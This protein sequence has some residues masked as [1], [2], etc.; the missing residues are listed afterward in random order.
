MWRALCNGALIALTIGL[1]ACE[2]HDQADARINEAARLTGE[3]AARLAAA[4]RGEIQIVDSPYYGEAVRVPL[5]QT[6]G[7]RLPQRV[8]AAKGST[9]NLRN[10]SLSD[11]A[12]A[13][14][15][16]NDIPVNIRTLYSTR[17]WDAVDVRPSA[18]ITL[19]HE[20]ALSRALDIVAART[21][22]Q[23]NYD[24]TA[25]VFD[26]MVTASY[27][28]P[29]PTGSSS[30]SSTV[31][32][33]QATGS[34]VSLSRNSRFE[35][36][37]EI[38]TRLAQAVPP[39]GE[40]MLNRNAGTI[41]VLGPPSVQAAAER[42]VDEFKAIYGARIGLEIGIFFVDSEKLSEFEGGIEGS[43][44]RYEISGL[45]TALAGNGVATLTG[46]N[47]TLSFRALA[48]NAAVV[49][50]RQASS[51]AQSGVW[52]PTIIRSSTN[53]VSGTETSTT[54]GVTST[55]IQTGTVDSGLSIHALPRI[56]NNGNIHLSLTILQSSLNGLDEFT[57]SDSTVQLP[58][59]DQR[60]LQNDAILSPGET[61]VLAGY[62][63]EY[64]T[65]TERRS[66]LF[67]GGTS[68]AKV[69]KV[70]MIVLVRPA[71][72]AVAEGDS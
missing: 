28:V 45:T 18:R 30:F 59:I 48:R 53:Y 21:D 57:S 22:T 2:T 58:S 31:D 36:W 49:D 65:R 5:G 24:G 12:T 29:L 10:S 43:G 47:A 38:E 27:Q 62:E 69:Y 67:L 23:W 35:P 26:S 40:F 16:Q 25:I 46:G 63:Q 56:V 11:F 34:T 55:S 33:L 71:I 8:E 54:D 3:Q 13:V 72:L 42:V 17:N 44:S 15:N 14:T 50:F 1:T 60:A 68:D 9:F 20:G 37:E 70:R 19:K 64:T 52:T 7:Q 61:L 4:Q 32:G 66:I 39:P 6:R 51:I 41:T